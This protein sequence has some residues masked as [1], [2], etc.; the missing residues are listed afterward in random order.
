M[1]KSH[2]KCSQPS[3]ASRIEQAIREVERQ[4]EAFLAEHRT[5]CNLD[6]IDQ[7]CQS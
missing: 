7:H 2:R 5:A 6:L 3:V 4:L 1:A